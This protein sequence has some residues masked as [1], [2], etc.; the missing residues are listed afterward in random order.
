MQIQDIKPGRIYSFVFSGEQKLNKGGRAGVAPNPLFG[1]VTK[2]A[3]YAG[4]AASGQMYMTAALAVNPQYTPSDRE[5]TFEA[6]EHPCVVRYL[7]DGGYAVRII[8]PRAVKTEYFVAGRPATA[9][10]IAL[11]KQYKPSRKDNPLHV[12]IMFPKV[13]HL[14][15][16]EGEMPAIGDGDEDWTFD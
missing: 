8:K 15:N 1:Q 2:R 5:S 16:L 9:E 10:E 12:R 4:Q 3:V 6:T 13:E 14:L 7:S 11:I